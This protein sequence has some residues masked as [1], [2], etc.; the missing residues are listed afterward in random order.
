MKEY[1]FIIRLPLSYGPE[2]AASVREQWTALT[3][4]WKADAIFVTSFIAPTDGYV[5]TGN[6]RSIA[7]KFIAS[8]DT[9]VI[10]NII[11]KAT[12]IDQATQLA[13]QCPILDQDGM[14]EVKEIQP[15]PE[16]I[17]KEIIRHLY[18]DI[19]NN[20]KIELL[21]ELISPD[22][23]GIGGVRGIAGFSNTVSSVIDGFPDIKWTI[24]DI[25][26]EGDKVIVRWHWNGT[27]TGA[28]RG[29]PASNKV[30]T[31]NAIAIYQLKNGKVTHAWLQGDR[32][33]I[34]TQIGQIQE[35]LIPGV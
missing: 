27:N 4:Q 31:D 3:D 16:V 8:G 19:L 12:D 28:F 35:T 9:K 34:L 26:S 13:Q 23:I 10:S 14:I 2:Q 11:I 1:L 25:L 5:I 32:L 15:R 21:K 30:V 18:E 29:I 33:G 7:R 20:R 17:N 24:E 22:Y 6:D